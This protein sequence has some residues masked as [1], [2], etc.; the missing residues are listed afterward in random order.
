MNVVYVVSS[1]KHAFS[2]YSSNLWRQLLLNK[3]L[4]TSLE[5]IYDDKG[6]WAS[7]WP[8]HFCSSCVFDEV[9]TLATDLPR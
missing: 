9:P 4:V 7:V 1:W 2:T 8:D 6:V 3:G 5:K